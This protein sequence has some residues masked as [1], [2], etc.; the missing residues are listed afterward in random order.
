[1]KVQTYKRIFSKD[2]DA[3]YQDLVD[4][5]SLSIN[6]GIEDLHLAL[7]NRLTFSDN[8][9]S[10]TIDVTVKVDESGVPSSEL[11]IKLDSS[12]K[13]NG[14]IVISC[15]NTVNSSSYP[16]SAPFATWSAT[17]NGV[18]IE[19]IT[20]LIANSEYTLKVLII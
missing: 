5:L 10:K 18:K 15:R 11:V 2:F 6:Q 20:G 14:I 9:Q 12:F 17:T 19:H 13:P 16:T 3:E 4:K 7:S 1:M 8:F